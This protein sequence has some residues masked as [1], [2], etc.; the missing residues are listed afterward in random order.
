MLSAHFL[1]R[2]E[3]LAMNKQTLRQNAADFVVYKKALGYIYDSPEKALSHYIRYAEETVQGIEYP[4]K[5]VTDK[6]LASISGSA[7]TL[8]HT[9]CVLREFSRYLQMRGCKGAYVIPPK[10]VSLPVAEDP[11]F[12]MPEEIE[13]FFEKLDSIK[14]HKSFKGREY[15]FPALFRLL[16]CCGLRCKEARTLECANVH[17][18]EYYIDVIQ[19]KGPKSRRIFISRELAEYLNEYDT[20]ISLLF[21]ERKYY[22]PHGSGC[23]GPAAVSGNFKRFW[24]YAFPDFVMTTRPR[25]YDFRHHF[26][27]ANLNRWAADGLDVNVMLP[28]LMRYMGHQSVS[29]TLYYFHFVPEFFPTYRTLSAPLEDIL[30]EVPDEE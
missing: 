13:A 11:Y 7:A 8:Y 29:E 22:F 28:Y 27:W 5:E 17:T 4:Q 25:A 6:Y 18:D 16:Y 9:V 2:G 30:P 21:P 20:N 15:V 14:P 3:V 19:S 1:C 24:K 10:M 23:Y 12:F 26:A